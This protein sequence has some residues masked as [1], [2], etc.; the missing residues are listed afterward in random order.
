MMDKKRMKAVSGVFLVCII[1][2]MC[3][4]SG[5]ASSDGV[6]VTDFDGI[7]LYELKNDNGLVVKITNYGATVTS[8]L[9][10][11]R[12]GD[13]ADIALGYDRVEDYMNA[14][15]K[16]YFGSIVGRYGN[17]IA[18]G[19]FTLGGETYTL[20][21]NNGANHL[22]GGVIGFDKVAWSAS[23][24][25][26]DGFTGLELAYLAKDR[27]EG[28]PGN[29][30]IKVTYKL[31]N[32]NE[33]VIDYYATTDKATPVNLTNHT[34]FNLAGEGNGTILGHKLMINAD[35]FTP[36]D[37]TLIPTG[38]LKPV[39]DTPFDFTNAKAIGRDIN[40]KNQQ[41]KFGGGYDHNF[42][43]NKDKGGMTLAATVY[44]PASGRFMEVLTEEPGIQF[45]C[46]NF[47]DGRLT[48]KAGKPYVHRGGFCLETQHYPDSPNQPEFPT[49]ILQP[50]HIY[51]TKTVYRFSTK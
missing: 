45:Y 36:V 15:D 5:C 32:N 29:L 2:L 4:V 14:V 12:K 49:T 30:D 11:D 35:R 17:R 33:L 18:T 40:K 1:T 23:P 43:L 8:I 27:E 3:M 19:Q 26:G 47:L 6:R 34:Y 9:V 22:H 42:V 7:A 44:E 39:K 24:I 20:A 21:T 51:K 16:P 28:Y 10:P 38:E 50:G 37:E 46:G 13:Y 41:L 48:G 31:N 25:S